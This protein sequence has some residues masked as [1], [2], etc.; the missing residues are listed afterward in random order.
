MLSRWIHWKPDLQ[1]LDSSSTKDYCFQKYDL[2]RKRILSSFC[3]WQHSHISTHLP[4]AFD[5][6]LDDEDPDLD[7]FVIPNLPARPE[8][9]P[10]S[11]TTSQITPPNPFALLAPIPPP[12]VPSNN[13][14]DS[15][16]DSD[17]EIP[18]LLDTSSQAPEA[19]TSVS[20]PSTPSILPAQATL[21][22]SPT[23][24][25]QEPQ[26]PQVHHS[27]LDRQ[28]TKRK[29]EAD[30]GAKITKTGPQTF[31]TAYIPSFAR[32]EEPTLIKEALYESPQSQ[33]WYQ[34][35]IHELESH[36]KNNTW[37]IVPQSTDWN[38][39]KTKFIYK[40]KDPDTPNPHY[41][42]RLVAQGFT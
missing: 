8:Y 22:S 33:Q 36:K 41:K 6:I 10:A 3:L 4:N 14:S 25:A 29:A 27:K 32:L 23:P 28:P 26:E 12:P 35:T 2:Q 11:S 21:P 1:A 37:T 5:D 13:D 42:A 24:S 17:D 15:D 16:S 19:S 38:I 40:L 39:I 9:L 18:D 31:S 34:A 30:A 20:P 7:D